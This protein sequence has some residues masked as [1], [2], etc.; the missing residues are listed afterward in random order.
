MTENN[1]QPQEAV[2]GGDSLDISKALVLGGLEGA[3]QKF[4]STDEAL[5]AA[6]YANRIGAL[7]QVKILLLVVTIFS[8]I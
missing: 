5:P 2:L 7:K 4:N 1:P 8:S 3:I 6:G